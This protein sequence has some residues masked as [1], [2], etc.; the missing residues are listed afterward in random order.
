V[1]CVSIL[2]KGGGGGELISDENATLTGR[3]FPLLHRD[4][5]LEGNESCPSQEARGKA[6]PG[7]DCNRR[8]QVQAR[9][10]D[11]ADICSRWLLLAT[12]RKDNTPSH[13]PSRRGGEKG[14]A[15]CLSKAESGGERR[16]IRDPGFRE[17]AGHP[18]KRSVRR[19]E[20]PN[21]CASSGRT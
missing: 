9:H 16:T 14:G 17:A 13:T 4:L 12:S 15:A 18:G 7:N 5:A 11:R 21:V 1:V 6:R 3:L 19:G 2:V 10:K 8:K 20:A